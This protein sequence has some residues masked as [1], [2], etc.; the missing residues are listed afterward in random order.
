MQAF[1][2]AKPTTVAEAVAL[3]GSNWNDAAIL[4]GGTDLLALM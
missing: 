2:Y 3:L 1:S 4:A